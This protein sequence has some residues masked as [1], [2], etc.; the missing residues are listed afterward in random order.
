MISQEGQGGAVHESSG[1]L[2]CRFHS[3]SCWESL[4]TSLKCGERQSRLVSLSRNQQTATCAFVSKTLYNSARH[5]QQWFARPC[6]WRSMRWIVH[7]AHPSLRC[8]PQSPSAQG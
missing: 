5:L 2:Q 1:P 4:L 8:L 3:A 6:C 7:D